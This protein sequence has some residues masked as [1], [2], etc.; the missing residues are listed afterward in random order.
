M[1]VNPDDIIDHNEAYDERVRL[2]NTLYLILT[3]IAILAYNG[4]ADNDIEAMCL[5][6]GSGCLA[7]KALSGYN[8]CKDNNLPAAQ[9]AEIKAIYEHDAYCAAVMMLLA[10]ARYLCK[11]YGNDFLQHPVTSYCLKAVSTLFFES[12]DGPK[13][14][15]LASPD[16]STS[17][18]SLD[19]KAL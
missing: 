6:A 13:E 7:Y 18:V 9:H 10:G 1:A 17:H 5:L 2:E 15:L 16:C 12:E 19:K 3:V 8:T 14:P 4:D 11:Y